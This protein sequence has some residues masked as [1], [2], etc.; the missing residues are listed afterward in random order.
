MKRRSK[1]DFAALEAKIAGKHLQATEQKQSPWYW[2]LPCVAAFLIYTPSLSFDFVHD[3]W[4]QIVGNVQIHSWSFL[5]RLLSTPLWSHAGPGSNASYYRPLFSLWML[6]VYTI[7][8]LSPG[9]WHLSSVLLHVA[10]TF[11]VFRISSKF[12]SRVAAGS[13]ALLFAIHP[14]H[15]EDVCWVSSSNEMLYSGL[16]LLS[17]LFLFRSQIDGAV[18]LR[19]SIAAWGAALLTKETAIALLPLFVVLAFWGS[20]SEIKKST[21]AALAYVAVAATYFAVRSIVLQNM[22]GKPSG[23]ASWRQV[24][25]TSPIVAKFYLGKL[26][27]PINLGAFHTLRLETEVTPAVLLTGAAISA[28]LFGIALVVIYSKKRHVWAV[29]AALVFLPLLPAIA[30]IHFFQ[31]VTFEAVHER[32]LYLPSVG[33][34]ILFG[35]FF[36]YARHR[37]RAF[38][39]G[40]AVV[41]VAALACLNLSQQAPYRD[42][43]ANSG[44]MLRAY[45][46]SINGIDPECEFMR[47]TDWRPRVVYP[48]LEQAIG[49]C[50]EGRRNDAQE[51][52]DSVKLSPSLSSVLFFQQNGY[53]NVVVGGQF[54]S[55]PIKSLDAADSECM[56][57][58]Q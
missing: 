27:C 51:I 28:I 18:W 13:A 54:W 53:L 41:M 15:I 8:G 48:L 24:L 46:A 32:Y 31:S 3:D 21:K 55:W 2:L 43:E 9:L 37:L 23:E 35:M 20:R 40:L 5:P 14:V 44:K 49:T 16:L 25:F 52:L 30:G 42:E 39:A 50:H 17:I 19:L 47:T 36:E 34:V 1:R 58:L 10:V 56:E 12:V 29:G 38:S 11:L 45:C 6:L 57:Q 7:A 4:M 26:V 22:L 33:L